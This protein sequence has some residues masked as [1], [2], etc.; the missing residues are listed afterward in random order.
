MPWPETCRTLMNIYILL[1][2]RFEIHPVRELMFAQHWSCS[3]GGPRPTSELLIPQVISCERATAGVEKTK[4]NKKKL[5]NTTALNACEMR[6]PGEEKWSFGI[7]TKLAGPRSYK[8]LCG[9]QNYRRN[10]CQLRPTSEKNLR[11]VPTS[12]LDGEQASSG[13]SSPVQ[14]VELQP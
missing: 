11:N 1:C 14:V 7:C 8:V 6:F 2:L 10:R 4:V 9:N 12:R 13:I 3:H 5:H